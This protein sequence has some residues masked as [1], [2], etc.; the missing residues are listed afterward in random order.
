[1][2]DD[3][4]AGTPRT[5]GGFDRNGRA[6]VVALFGL[7]GAGIG[8]LFPLL[9]GWAAELPWMPFQGPLRLLGS[10]DQQ[11]LVW[12]RP[13]LG[14]LAG[15]AFAAW[16]IV[17]SPVLEVDPRRI[18]VRRRG[19]TQRVIEREK[20][21]AVYPR[22]SKLVIE[23]EDG[24]VLFEGDVEGERDQIRETLVQQGYPWEGPSEREPD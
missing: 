3:G 11:W 21:A 1:M 15:L 2:T 22:G 20:V 18:Q 10:F 6:W 14:L 24:R 9:A 19:E 16:V 13:L 4:A 8:A 7:A 5:V 17:D 23:T 12:G